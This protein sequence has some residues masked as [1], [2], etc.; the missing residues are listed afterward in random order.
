[1]HVEG[2]VEARTAGQ[3]TSQQFTG[4]FSLTQ[5]VLRP[6]GGKPGRVP[7]FE[8]SPCSMGSVRPGL[9]DYRRLATGE[10]AA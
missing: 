1:M 6:F 5:C 2:A 8:N 3:T 4:I 9:R 10:A 7:P